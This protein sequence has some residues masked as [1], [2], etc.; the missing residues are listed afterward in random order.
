MSTIEQWTMSEETQIALDL[1]KLIQIAGVTEWDYIIIGDGSATTWHSSG[2][3]ASFVYDRQN[4]TRTSVN[5]GMNLCSV[6]GAE[7]MAALWPLLWLSNAIPREKGRKPVV[8]VISDRKTLTDTFASKT[9]SRGTPLD[10]T[11]NVLRGI[12][13][14]R[15][16]WVSRDDLFIHK[17]CHNEAN[18]RRIQFNEQS[19]SSDVTEYLVREFIG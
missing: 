19:V 16:V 8:I 1:N 10:A 15:S 17:Q 3:W 2:G 14:I 18:R 12:F 13:D 5:G 7:Y 9:K 11:V 4:R 6:H